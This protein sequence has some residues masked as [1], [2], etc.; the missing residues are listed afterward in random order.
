[1]KLGL[2]IFQ[3]LLQT[4]QSGSDLLGELLDGACILMARFWYLGE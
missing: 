3:K 2:P 4:K 1:M